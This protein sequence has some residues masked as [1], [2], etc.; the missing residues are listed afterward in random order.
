MKKAE[1]LKLKREYLAEQKRKETEPLIDCL[2]CRW[3]SCGW[4]EIP[5]A[6]L[7]PYYY[8]HTCSKMGRVICTQTVGETGPSCINAPADCPVRLES[9]EAEELK[10][11][12]IKLAKKQLEKLKMYEPEVKDWKDVK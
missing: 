8:D 9:K 11:K 12:R 10:K 5:G 4:R 2:S 1:K 3:H 6:P 7:C